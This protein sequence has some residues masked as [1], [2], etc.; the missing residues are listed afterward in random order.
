MVIGV[1]F[2]V[3]GE[4]IFQHFAYDKK[5]DKQ[6]RDIRLNAY[7]QFET[8]VKE[9]SL[10]LYFIKRRE[11]PGKVILEYEFPEGAERPQNSYFT[12]M[13]FLPDN[14]G[15]DFCKYCKKIEGSPFIWC[16]IKQK[17]LPHKVKNCKFFRQKNENF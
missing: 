8:K 15:C 2:Y 3:R 4:K 12:L 6:L 14:F 5:F 1:R 10:D 13:S 17:T 16:E 7:E 9:K 11:E